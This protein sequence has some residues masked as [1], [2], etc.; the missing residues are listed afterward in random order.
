[1]KFKNDRLRKEWE[2]D[3]LNVDL[4]RMVLCIEQMLLSK[5]RYEPTITSIFRTQEEQDN[6]Y[7]DREDYQ[8]KPWQS[9]HQFWRGVDLRNRDMSKEMIDDI[10]FLNGIF[11]YDETRP[12][13]R[14]I[15]SHDIGKGDHIHCQTL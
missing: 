5:Y 8:K 3:D 1:M 4:R 2:S 13:K 11:I 12:H 14:C 7:G 9:V 6:Y 10:V 15:I